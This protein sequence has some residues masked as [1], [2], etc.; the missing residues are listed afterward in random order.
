MG[1][2]TEINEQVL[3]VEATIIFTEPTTRPYK[4]FAS[5]TIMNNVSSLTF[6]LSA[7]GV[8]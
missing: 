2:D 8:N 4:R 7:S 5:S 3:C 1:V 6:I